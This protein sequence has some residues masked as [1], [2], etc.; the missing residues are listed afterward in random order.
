MRLGV[1]LRYAD[2]SRL[3][4][5]NVDVLVI[6]PGSDFDEFDVKCATDIACINLNDYITKG[7]ISSLSQVTANFI[8]EFIKDIDGPEEALSC[9]NDLYQYHLRVQYLFLIAF[10]RYLKSLRNYTVIFDTRRFHK[11]F[12]PMR[13]DLGIL[14]SSSQTLA[15]IGSALVEQM[16][17]KVEFKVNG[18]PNFVNVFTDYFRFLLR[19]K[20]TSFFIVSKIFQKVIFSTVKKYFKTSDFVVTEFDSD[21]KIGIIVRTDSEVIS[22]SY[23]IDYYKSS[24]DKYIVIQDEILSSTTTVD[25]L[26]SMNIKYVPVGYVGG[27]S[28]LLSSLF[29]SSKLLYSNYPK[30]MSINCNNFSEE[31]L[32]KDNNVLNELKDRLLDFFVPQRHFANELSLMVEKFNISKLI[33]FA[34]VDQWGGVVKSVGDKYGIKTIAIQNAAQDPEEY[35]R[36]CWAD[37]YCVESMYL[38]RRLIKLGYPEDKITGTGLPHYTVN[39]L[40]NQI[41]VNIC[42][43][44]QILILTQPIYDRYYNQLI[45]AAADFCAV[46][47][48]QLAIKYHPRQLGNEYNTSIELARDK[49]VVKVYKSESLDNLVLSSKLAVSV[50]SAAILRSLNLGVPTLSFLPKSEKYLDLYYTDSANLFVVSDIKSFRDFLEMLNKDYAEFLSHFEEKLQH[51]IAEHCIFE[52]TQ[53][54]L[55]NVASIIHAV[56]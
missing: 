29:Q 28:T 5:R 50:V 7:E 10:E 19:K 9:Q 17:G 39:S 15:F 20:I 52:N 48:Y 34:Y 35:P 31:V 45:E 25:R 13:P 40:S 27:F 26:E 43:N 38:K 6:I 46:H 24:G 2:L 1:L 16:G 18:L 49:C 36:L 56:N 51:Y 30:A 44:N 21:N 41:K 47:D 4:N 3:I 33:T 11:Y 55:L 14:Y 42:D 54:P 12:S 32:F 8:R 37:H 23:L 53:V 22:A